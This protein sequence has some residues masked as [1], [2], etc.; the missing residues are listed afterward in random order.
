MIKKIIDLGVLQIIYKNGHK[1]QKDEIEW[2]MKANE[3]EACRIFK[4]RV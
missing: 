1:D 4:A 3:L 2:H